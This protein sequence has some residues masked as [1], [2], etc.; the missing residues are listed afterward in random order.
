[1]PTMRSASGVQTARA[2]FEQKE[3]TSMR[4]F[5]SFIVLALA[6]C[7]T[8]LA[9]A[10][11]P[12]SLVARQQAASQATRTGGGYRDVNWRFGVVP[13]RT[14]VVSRS[15]GGYRDMNWRFSRLARDEVRMAS[16]VR[17]ARWR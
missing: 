3:I 13:A 11:N 14:P 16:A 7:T 1:M 4:S 10:R 8:S 5:S 2:P 15:A 12:P 6:L 9:L 17:P